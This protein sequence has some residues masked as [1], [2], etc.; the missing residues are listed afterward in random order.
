MD[1][2]PKGNKDVGRLDKVIADAD[3]KTTDPATL[4]VQDVSKHYIT[5]MFS[6]KRE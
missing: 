2:N 3:N 4:A 6:R 1:L 5:I